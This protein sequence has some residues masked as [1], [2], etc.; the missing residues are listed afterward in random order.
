[1]NRLTIALATFICFAGQTAYGVTIDDIEIPD[2]LT[3]PS[4]SPELVLNGAGMRKKLFMDIYI[5]ALYLPAR[6]NDAA[7]IL[8]DDG[9]ASVAMHIRYGEISRDKIIGGWEDGIT[10]NLDE[11]G[12]QAIR[13]RLDAF[14]SLFTAVKEGD[15]IRIDYTPG[16]GTEVRI[17]GEWRGAIEGNDFFRALL[18]IWLGH[19]PVRESLKNDMLGLD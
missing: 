7:A 9:P 1:M 15:V 13:T 2:S 10:A 8:E 4:G 12:Q 14:N 11:S 5:G 16:R 3:L 17:N 19:K 6:T 18:K